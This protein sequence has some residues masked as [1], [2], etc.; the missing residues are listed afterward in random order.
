MRDSI[1]FMHETEAP[2]LE[3]VNE[4]EKRFR[5]ELNNLNHEQ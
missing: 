4:L 2:T 3:Q 5:E 1:I